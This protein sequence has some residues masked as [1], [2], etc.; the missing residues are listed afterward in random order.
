MAA[1][2]ASACRKAQAELVAV[3]LNPV[4]A[5]WKDRPAPPLGVV[6]Q[7]KAR[8]AG[9]SALA[10]IAGVRAALAGADGLLITDPHNL[11]WLFNIR[12]ADVSHTPLPLGFAYVRAEGRPI[13]FLDSAEAL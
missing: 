7:H 1:L 10:K 5:I 12:G 9:E 3:D 6:T 4:D 2:F 8:Y 13:L 11:A